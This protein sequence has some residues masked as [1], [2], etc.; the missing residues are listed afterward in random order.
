MEIVVNF[1]PGIPDETTGF[2]PTIPGTPEPLDQN[3]RLLLIRHLHFV[4]S[5]RAGL[6]APYS[7]PTVPPWE[8]R[9]SASNRFS[10]KA[11]RGA[12]PPVSLSKNT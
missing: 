3:L 10:S 11:W 12:Y 2:G 8:N 1:P 6:R 9:R 4:G 5:D 7:L